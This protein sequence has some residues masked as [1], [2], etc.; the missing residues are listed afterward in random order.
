VVDDG[1]P[2]SSLRIPGT[3]PFGLMWPCIEPFVFESPL[4]TTYVT[5]DMVAFRRDWQAQQTF[6]TLDDATNPVLTAHD[7][8]FV[9]QPGLRLLVGR[10]MNDWFALEASY[11]GLLDWN[12]VRDVR[13]TT[14][15]T[16]GTEGNMFSPFSNFGNPP[17]VGFDYNNFASI[18]MVTTFHNAE[19]NLRQRLATPPS[20]LQATAIWGLRYINVQD[21]FS[22][23]TQ[24]L[25]PDPDGTNTAINVQAS[26]NLF[27]VQVGGA[28]EFQVERRCWLLFEAKG[29]LLANSASQQTS[30]STGPLAGPNSTTNGSRSQG[31]AMLG[32]DLAATLEWK[33]TPAIIARFGYQGI[34]L[35]G[36]SL[37]SDNFLRN[38]A[39]MTTDP[40]VLSDDGHLAYQ[41]PFAGVT[42]TW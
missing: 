11:L 26:N 3:D 2:V 36:L 9:Y 23:R 22:Y 21:K 13:N 8:P 28:V 33:I 29:M 16:L 19:L 37:G 12:E 5:A 39:N 10:R 42:V 40:N 6:A 31:R 41:G 32:G 20:C 7:L 27:G 24:S 14:V 25:E 34:F 15:N 38:L 17:I 30:Y 4:N 1:Y 18:R 35:D